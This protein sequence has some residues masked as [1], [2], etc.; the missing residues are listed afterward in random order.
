MGLIETSD[1][2]ILAS[3]A[4]AL[5]ELL[6][7]A[8]GRTG[9]MRRFGKRE[10]LGSDLA[11]EI[12]EDREGNLWIASSDGGVTQILKRGFTS[13]G[14]ED[15]IPKPDTSFLVDVEGEGVVAG[16]AGFLHRFDGVRF[17][18]VRLN[19]PA[20][21]FEDPVLLGWGWGQSILRDREGDWWIP[22][23]TGIYRFGR[24][25]RLADLASAAPKA[26]YT[27]K[28]GLA[29]NAVFRLFED[30]RGDVWISLLG[31]QRPLA[32]W[33]RRRGS[34]TSH[35]VLD[36]AGRRKTLA[37]TA[38]A[39]DR[40]GEVWVGFFD[41]GLARCCRKGWEHFGAE[42]GAPAGFVNAFLVDGKGRLWVGSNDG[43]RR[44]NDPGAPKPEFLAYGRKHG[45][46]SEYVTSLA[47]D[48]FGRIYI[49]M[50]SRVSVLDPDEE[51]S[52][53]SP[54]LSHY[55]GAEG[56]LNGN[57]RAMIRDRQGAIWAGGVNGVFRFDPEPRKRGLPAPAVRFMALKLGGVPL[58]ISE[59]GERH[60]SGYSFSDRGGAVEV[61][62]SLPGADSRSERR[63]S[64]LLEGSGGQWT[65]LSSVQAIALTGL[66]AGRYRLLVKAA[67]E[68]EPGEEP[69]V[70]EF[71]VTAPF[72]RRGWFMGVLGAAVGLAAFWM[73]WSRYK[74]ALALERMRMQI[75][76]DLH[77][78]LGA[79]LTQLALGSELARLSGDEPSK[80]AA[81]GQA[82]GLAREMI[83][84]VSDLVF[85]ISPRQDDARSLA[86][87]MR[88]V[89]EEAVAAANLRLDFEA[90]G[91]AADVR[92]DPEQRRQI[93]AVFREAVRNAVKHSGGTCVA[94]R[95]RL[96]DAALVLAVSDDGRGLEGARLIESGCTHGIAGMRWRAQIL[97]GRLEMGSAGE[98]G[99]KVT[100]RVPLR[101]KLKARA[102]TGEGWARESRGQAEPC[103]PSE[104]GAR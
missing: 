19:L 37:P 38:F 68:G 76:T 79:G 3:V 18:T 86:L 81:L 32:T 14:R 20:E 23:E 91:E 82:A 87:R 66:S 49:G 45:L 88:A 62:F 22:T 67:A 29:S 55:S 1:G 51:T 43:L 74:R 25:A 75:A 61:G 2:R 57:V 104:G 41:G 13:F 70:F 26:H 50:H 96:E 36:G 64:Y 92:L 15:G 27:V 60:L 33:V 73:R 84:S 59:F 16:R 95:M 40:F 58:Q 72:Y 28:D 98:K 89:A 100:L 77:D 93:L 47:E 8:E 71:S 44:V 35:E 39:E 24:P 103:R 48:H 31:T 97:G 42:A 53:G 80:T 11:T 90:S 83:G 101:R 63:Y 5:N 10:G 21:L 9:R 69:A 46:P 4:D 17:H 85:A 52:G 94:V 12:A 34:F 6:P 30:S 54:R 78:E 102:E 7:P 99:L 65:P 56:V